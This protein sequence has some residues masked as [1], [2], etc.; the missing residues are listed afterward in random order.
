M[1]LLSHL[2]RPKGQVKEELRLDPVAKR[3]GELLNQKVY[4]TDEALA[5]QVQKQVQELKE[6]ER[7]LLL[8]SIRFYPE[9]EQ[10]DPHF[11]KQLAELGEVYVNDAFGVGPGPMRPPKEWPVFCRP[12]LVF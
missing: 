7:V 3:L 4:K 11:A 10:N 2:G 12:W 9:E 6:G 5:E 1:I 8:E